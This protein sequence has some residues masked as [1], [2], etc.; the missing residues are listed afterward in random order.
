MLILMIR[1]TMKMQLVV[2]TLSTLLLL[3]SS[4]ICRLIGDDKNGSAGWKE[5]IENSV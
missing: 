2:S 5:P 4:E 3:L 1:S